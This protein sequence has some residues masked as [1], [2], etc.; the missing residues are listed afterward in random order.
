MDSKNSPRLIGLTGTNGAGKGEAAAFLRNKGYACFSLSDIL[1]EKLREDG[2]EPS[3][4]HLIAKGNALRRQG[5]PDILARLVMERVRERAVI[6]SIRN[7]SEVAYL[8]NQPGFLLVGIDAPA[9]LRFG[10]LQK[11]GRN[12][13]ARTLEEFIRKE[14]EENSGD[15]DG[16]QLRKCL[17]MA[18]VLI[19]ND[20]PLEELHRRLEEVLR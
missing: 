12:E 1:R 6:D 17:A 19:F 11:R 20:G 15:P 8:R 16:Q 7:P 9:A 10:R 4:D 2:L 5:G 14:G 3:R 13:S 18:D